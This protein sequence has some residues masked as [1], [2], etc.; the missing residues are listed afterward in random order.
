LLGE[1]EDKD[2]DD[3]DEARKELEKKQRL[4]KETIEAIEA[5]EKF[6]HEVKM[7]W[8]NP[9]QRIIGHVVSS[10]CVTVDAGTEGF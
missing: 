10:P 9:K 1:G 2:K 6:Y 8:S 4:L 7:D 3:T 5:L